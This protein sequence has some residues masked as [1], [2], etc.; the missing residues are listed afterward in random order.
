MSLNLLCV[1]FETSGLD[2]R[3]NKHQPLACG[4]I[5]LDFKTLKIKAE[6]Y[7]ECQFHADRFEWGQKA[8]EIHGLTREHLSTQPTMDKAA[9]KFVEFCLPH[10]KQSDPITLLGHNPHFDM[11][12]LELWLNEID[13]KMTFGH[14]RLDTFSIG[15]GLFGAVN[16]EQ[17]F[18]RVGIKRSYHNALEDARA[19]V[20]ALQMSRKVGAIYLELLKE[21]EEGKS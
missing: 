3:E 13:L 5:V 11:R 8:E 6:T 2:I 19:T 1:D 7:I 15:F 21:H 20:G 9:M 14:R 12:C 17:L 4:A 18:N 10:F 16:S